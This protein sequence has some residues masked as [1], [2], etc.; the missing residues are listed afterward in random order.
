MYI[1]CETT[2]AKYYYARF[3]SSEN[4]RAFRHSRR[5][6][7]TNN[8]IYETRWGGRKGLWFISTLFQNDAMLGASYYT[9]VS[10]RAT[11]R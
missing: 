4:S 11:L 10:H 7:C 2:P 5:S 9:A 6:S 3:Y 8:F 1:S